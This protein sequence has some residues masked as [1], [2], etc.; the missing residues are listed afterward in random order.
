MR[1]PFNNFNPTPFSDLHSLNLDWILREMVR[2]RTEWE[3]IKEE[4]DQM[5]VDWATFQ[6]NMQRLWQEY[7][8]LMDA[9]YAQLRQ[10][11]V[12]YRD[13]LDDWKAGVDQSITDF[14]SAWETYKQGVDGN[15]TSMQTQI[16]NFIS[17]MEDY[18]RNNMPAIVSPIVRE[19]LQEH[20]ITVSA[21][22]RPEDE[23]GMI[24][25]LSKAAT[26]HTPILL[27]PGEDYY[28]GVN[29]VSIPAGTIIIGYGA[30]I[31]DTTSVQVSIGNQVHIYGLDFHQMGASSSIVVA[32]SQVRLEEVSIANSIAFTI[33]VSPSGSSATEH[34]NEITLDQV[35]YGG[36]INVINCSNLRDIN[37]TSPH[38]YNQ[39]G[40]NSI[41]T[42][43]LTQVQ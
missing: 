12:D 32:G 36:P 33:G 25:A 15:L 16:N 17:N 23:G 5:K 11:W 21:F 18:I 38:S 4:W 30:R 31:V 13:V 35:S 9:A 26:E 8:N 29:Q 39:S 3:G 42:S 7:K 6:A 41:Y 43:V 14:E 37:L 10:E 20:G 34:V 40:S 19:W 28:F 24:Q 1:W 27:T 22:I 2:L